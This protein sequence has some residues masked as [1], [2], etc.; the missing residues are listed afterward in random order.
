MPMT[1]T[2]TSGGSLLLSR[3][4]WSCW[5][6]LPGSKQ[7]PALLEFSPEALAPIPRPLCR[8]LSADGRCVELVALKQLAAGEEATI[9]YTGKGGMTNQRLMAQYGVGAKGPQGV[10][11]LRVGKERSKHA[12]NAWHAA[13]VVAHCRPSPCSPAPR[14]P[15]FVP[16]GSNPADRLQFEALQGAAGAA[17]GD[18]SDSDG[19][20]S[21]AGSSSSGSVLL[22]LDRMQAA[23]GDGERMAAALSGRDAYRYAVSGRLP[24]EL[25]LPACASALPHAA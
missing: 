20:A 16:T 4:C 7:E 25:P 3:C 1:P 6:A 15:Q 12:V 18:Y 9:S 17:P 23:L 2:Q 19:S 5:G 14:P 22:S 10:L 11:P 13:T 24:A 21:S 8:R